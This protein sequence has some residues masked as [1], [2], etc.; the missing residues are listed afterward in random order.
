MHNG[1]TL[2]WSIM[3]SRWM[4]AGTSVEEMS[5]PVSV[6]GREYCLDA[7]GDCVLA[8]WQKIACRVRGAARA[9]AGSGEHAAAEEEQQ[10]AAD[11]R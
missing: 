3:S 6:V 2:T 5:L 7:E 11:A 8:A 10:G 4:K 9:L 1:P